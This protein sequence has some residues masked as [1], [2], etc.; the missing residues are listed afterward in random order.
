MVRHDGGDRV[1]AVCHLDREPGRRDAA[2]FANF[3][4]L[5]NLALN[6]RRGTDP[7]DFHELNEFSPTQRK[8]KEADNHQYRPIQPMNHMDEHFGDV[9]P[10]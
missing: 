4:P 1:L 2:P 7:P 6:Q 3:F 5:Q 10:L 9:G 8:G